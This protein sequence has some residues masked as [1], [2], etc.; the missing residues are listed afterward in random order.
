MRLKTNAAEITASLA[1]RN[2]RVVYHWTPVR[3]LPSVLAHGILCRRE[4]QRRAISFDP[5]SYGAAGKAED[6][7][8]HVCVSFHP[9]RA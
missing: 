2:R 9:R 5:H 4:L 7:A 6:F 8:G 1:R 3:L